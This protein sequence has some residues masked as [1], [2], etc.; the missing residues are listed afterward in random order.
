[1]VEINVEGMLGK[2]E[3][4][5]STMDKMM[6]DILATRKQIS[7]FC[8]STK[9]EQKLFKKNPEMNINKHTWSGTPPIDTL[10]L[11]V[12]GLFVISACQQDTVGG[13]IVKDECPGGV[14]PNPDNGVG[15]RQID[16]FEEGPKTVVQ[17]HRCCV[18]SDGDRVCGD[19]TLGGCEDDSCGGGAECERGTLT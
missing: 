18:E 15:A 2:L 3:S 12:L 14:C 6:K 19:F 4:D 8:K 17:I 11:L 7:S 1:M 10:R 5:I 9:K 16:D 13:R